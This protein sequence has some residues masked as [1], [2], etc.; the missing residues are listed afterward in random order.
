MS[1]ERK[2]GSGSDTLVGTKPYF[3]RAIH[4]WSV[5]NG[6][7]PQV[8]VNT[9][10]D[11]VVVPEQY[12]RD[13]RIILNVHPQSVAQLEMG[14]DELSFMARFSGIS[15]RLSVPVE[16]VMAIYAREN[17]QGIVFQDEPEAPAPGPEADREVADSADDKAAGQKRR[18]GAPHLKLVK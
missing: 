8:L 12:V 6:F 10:Y 7:T 2:D 3:I 5:D 1:A 13:H 4:E 9:E 18:S 11:G 17:G 16:A 15:Y 14:N